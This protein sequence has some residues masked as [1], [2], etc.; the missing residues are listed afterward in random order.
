M[1]ILMPVRLLLRNVFF[2]IQVKTIRLEKFTKAPL[3][4]TG[5][6]RSKRGE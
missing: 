2:F 4:W 1:L 6:F 3:L 5:W